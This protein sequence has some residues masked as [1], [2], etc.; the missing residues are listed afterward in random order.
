MSK[1]WQ[2]K[3]LGEC[4][5]GRPSYGANSASIDFSPSLPRY[6]RITDISESGSLTNYNPRSIEINAAEGNY[7]EKGDIVFARS[8]ATVGKTYLHQSN[9]ILA[10]AGY[11]IRFRPNQK[12]V[13]PEYLFLFTQSDHY[14]N[15]IKSNIRT[16]AQP[17]VNAQEYSKM[18]IPLPSLP[19]QRKIATI[20]RTWDDAIEK[21]D[22]LI[23]KRQQ[24]KSILQIKIFS[25]ML[26]PK[27]H[28]IKS[29]RLYDIAVSIIDGDR[30]KNYPK[31]DDFSSNA[32]CLFLSAKNVTND[33]FKFDEPQFI[34]AKKDR[35]MSKGK[36][37]RNDI[38]L[39]TR[40]TV[41]NIAWFNDT[42]P[43]HSIRINSGMVIIRNESLELDTEFLYKTLSSEIVKNQIKRTVF[44]SAQP[45]LTLDLIRNF[46]I[47][48]PPVKKQQ[49]IA[50]I[51]R[52]Y[53]ESFE[54][55]D[56]YKRTLNSQKRGLMQKLLTGQWRVNFD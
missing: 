10:Y 45:Q 40:G 8:G 12:I 21:I 6:L 9:D 3:N 34:S 1:G 23:K 4:C 13:F 18:I 28:R 42:V 17:N 41:G 51:L 16:G 15:W 27:N 20:L 36:L 49:K 7:V 24:E 14:K 2:E 25:G 55:L 53:D 46:K 44:G 54:K 43:Y 37:R 56:K 11:L 30:G 50:A 48:L 38:V 5:I 22:L 52:F 32:D 29:V 35:L 31:S 39:T 47:P 19:E 33:G 26:I